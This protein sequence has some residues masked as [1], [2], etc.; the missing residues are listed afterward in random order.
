MEQD[1]TY[2]PCDPA[3][4]HNSDRVVEERVLDPS[5]LAPRFR[6]LLTTTMVKGLFLK[7][8]ISNFHLL[9]TP[10]WLHGYLSYRSSELSMGKAV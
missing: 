7:L 5:F 10:K 6:S 9:C 1:R 3:W 8:Y 2:I 4:A